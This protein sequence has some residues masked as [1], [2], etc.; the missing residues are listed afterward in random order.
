MNGESTWRYTLLG[1]LVSVLPLLIVLKMVFIQTNPGQIEALLNQQK[2]YSGQMQV[3]RPARGKIMDRWGHLLAGNNTVYEVGV[4]LNQMRNPETI[5]LTAELVLG[6]DQ[7]KAMNMI[8]EGLQEGLVRVVLQDFVTQD[9]VLLLDK[10]KKQMQAESADNGGPNAPSLVGLESIPHLMRTYPE[11]SL[12]SNVL[13]FVAGSGQGYFGVEEK[14]DNLLAGKS[15]TVWVPLDPNLI[16]EIPETPEGASL[17]L[18]LDRSIQASVENIL[19]HALDNTGADSG[20]I[21]VMDPK[22]GELLAMATTPRLD[23]NDYSR[24]LDLFDNSTPFNRAVSQ[25]YEPGSVYKVLTMAAG[26]DSGTVEP[27]TV[28]LDTGVFEIGGTYIYN[29]NSGAWGPQDMTGCL[30]HSLNVCM[31]WIASETGAKD[32]YSYMRAFGIGHLSGV[33]LAGEV[34]GRLKLPGDEDWYDADLGTN[35]F[36]QGVSTSPLQMAT[37]V[38]AIANEGKMMA[39]HIVRSM[40]NKGYQYDIEQRVIGTP[41]STDTAKTLSEMLA[42]SL[43]IES[44]DALVNGYRVAGKTGTAEIPTPFGY[45]SNQTNAS[46]VGWGPVDDPRFLVYVWLERPATSIWGS[47]V[48]AP[49]FRQVVEKLVVLLELPPDDIRLK[50]YGQ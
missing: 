45:T 1:I 20:T 47:E 26:L 27:Q 19:D 39:P 22:T 4:E 40:V 24:Y 33:D 3:F 17:I 30:Q 48:A 36:G 23:L 32:F 34:A 8:N 2:I 41:I 7:S 11:K 46:F 15:K 49:V 37:A 28:F 25:A 16:Q 6:M 9:K 35:A 43:E 44:S 14:Y 29:W 12:A 13:G 31:A 38:S 42:Q 21:L 50:L 18:T 10:L 5:A